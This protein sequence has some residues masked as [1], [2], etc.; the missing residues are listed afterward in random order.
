MIFTPPIA[1]R[2]TVDLIGIKNSSVDY[3][4][5]EAIDQVAAELAKR[6]I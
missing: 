2:T 3:W 5:Q 6:K 1:E 4:Q